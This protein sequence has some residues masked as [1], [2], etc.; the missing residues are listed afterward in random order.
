MTQEERKFII[1]TMTWSF[2]RLNSFDNCKFEWLLKY[3]EEPED[4]LGSCY[5]QFGSLCHSLLENYAN[6]EI[7]LFDLPNE[8]ERRFPEITEYFPQRGNKDI[9]SEYFD[10]G[11][12][13]FCNFTGFGESEIL[14]VEKKIE[15]KLEEYPFIGFIDLLLKDKNTGEIVILDHKSSTLKFKK[16]GQLS[17]TSLPKFDEFKKQLYL[18]SIPIVEEY[19]HVDKLKWNLFKDQKS[20]EIPWKK[21]EFE[22]TK[23]WAVNKIQDIKSEDS[24]MPNPEYMYCGFLCSKRLTCPYKYQLPDKKEFIPE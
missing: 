21:K 19:G 8:F 14:G 7:G 24:W 18:Y 17:K 13:Y 15:F 9:R 22:E 4:S 16:N 5:A 20:L 1:D 10:K 2:S 3:I 12:N 6:G 23:K 11:Y